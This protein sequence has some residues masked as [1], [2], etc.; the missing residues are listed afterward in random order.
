MKEYLA[1]LKELRH[2]WKDEIPTKI[3][4]STSPDI[5][6]KA[7]KAWFQLVITELQNG[8]R[9]EILEQD[10]YL[11]KHKAYLE[12]CEGLH[13]RDTTPEDIN[14]TNKLLDEM[15]EHVQQKI[16]RKK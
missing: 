2:D 13:H 6:Y 14:H 7:R 4:H 12:F 11:K 9:N 10:V 5:L 3:I 15:I 8:L 16:R 1:K